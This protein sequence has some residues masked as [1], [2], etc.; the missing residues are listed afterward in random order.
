MF[1]NLSD[2]EKVKIETFCQDEVMFDAVKK[3]ILSIMYGEGVIGKDKVSV[4]NTAFNLIARKREM[5]EDVSDEALGQNL[6][7]LYEGVDAL[8]N[9]LAKLKKVTSKTESPYQ[10]ENEAI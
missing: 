6:R 9:A 8:E 10:E 1:E 5:G 3:G 4:R 2:I 7:G